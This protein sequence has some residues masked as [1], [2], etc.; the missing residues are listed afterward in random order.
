VPSPAASAPLCFPP[1]PAAAA[2]VTG[3]RSTGFYAPALDGLRCV[4]VIAVLIHHFS[5]T[6]S[7][8]S[9][10]GQWAVRLFF[11][12]S[13]FLITLLL[14]E[15]RAK[16]EDGRLAGRSAVRVF[17]IRRIFRLWPA[18]FLCLAVAYCFNV[19]P[20]RETIWWHV[21][22]VTNQYVF[23]VQGWPGMLSHFWTLAVE[24]QFY[25]F[26]PFVILFAPKRSLNL[27][28][29]A[30]LLTG[31]LSREIIL[32]FRWSNLSTIYTP[33]PCCLDF[34]AIGG[35]I[36]WGHRLGWLDRFATLFRL[37]LL[38]VPAAGW[39]LYGVFLKTTDSIFPAY[40]AVF[41]PLIQALGF[42]VLIVYVLRKPDGFTARCLSRPTFV[43]IG[44]IS[45]GIY[46]YHN[47]MHWFGP[48]VLR[49]TTGRSYL[50]NEPL[51]LV[52][53]IVLSFI[54][55]VASYHFLEEPVRRWGRRFG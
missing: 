24:Q 42:G 27:V 53:Y 35:M 10:L 9:E 25:L 31:P 48:A 51:H 44:G 47:F 1:E 11:V 18:Y 19:A 21:F 55:A 37:R 5:P 30:V 41:D 43:Y 39:L 6:I 20:T 32:A 8:F 28:L 26:W 36:A 3:G 50:P 45:Y 12:L 34:F 17:F 16:I 33:L 49:H 46:V 29:L 2:A 40:W 22:M 15:A 54:L 14:L 4:A 13:G 7:G 52:Y 38:L 23:H